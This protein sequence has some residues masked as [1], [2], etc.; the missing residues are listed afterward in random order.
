V[1]DGS[2]ESVRL[3]LVDNPHVIGFARGSEAGPGLAVFCNSDLASAQN[4]RASLATEQEALEDILTGDRIALSSGLISLALAPGQV[5][6]FRL[7]TE[8]DHDGIAR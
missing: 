5:A 7:N 2:A 1:T 8:S 6:A 4:V 3:L